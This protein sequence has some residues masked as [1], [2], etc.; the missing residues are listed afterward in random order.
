M[1]GLLCPSRVSRHTRGHL[2]QALSPR[3]E[4]LPVP[5]QPSSRTCSPSPAPRSASAAGTCSSPRTLTE[6]RAREHAPGGPCRPSR[7]PGR[8]PAGPPAGP[9]CFRARRPGGSLPGWH[10]RAPAQVSSGLRGPCFPECTLVRLWPHLSV[11]TALQ[12]HRASLCQPRSKAP[13]H[14][15]GPLRTLH[16]LSTHHSLPARPVSSPLRGSALALSSLL[17]RGHG[18][19]GAQG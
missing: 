19:T 4:P 11:S 14:P 9:P 15:P 10:P 8:S 7:R 1:P 17:T 12:G 13:V 3:A 18:G 16:P 5:S 6:Q 2:T